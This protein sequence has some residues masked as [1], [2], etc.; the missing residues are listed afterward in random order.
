MF[1]L[2]K[3]TKFGEVAPGVGVCLYWVSHTSVPR[4]RG[5]SLPE[6]LFTSAKTVCPKATTFGMAPYMWRVW[7]SIRNNNKMLCGDQVTRKENVYAV[8]R[9]C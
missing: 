7:H 6:C 1:F 5:S 3:V 9:E 4:G 8:C 2:S